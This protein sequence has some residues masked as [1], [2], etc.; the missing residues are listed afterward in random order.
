MINWLEQEL[1]WDDHSIM[2]VSQVLEKLNIIKNEYM[3]G[4]KKFIEAM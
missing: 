1:Y 3:A 2:F 4:R